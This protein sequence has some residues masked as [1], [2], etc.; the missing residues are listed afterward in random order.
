MKKQANAKPAF[1]HRLLPPRVALGV[2][3]LAALAV[4]VCVTIIQWQR[5]QLTFLEAE[6][7]ALQQVFLN[8]LVLTLNSHQQRTSH[9]P[10]A[11][12]ALSE[13]TALL[14]LE[15]DAG[16]AGPPNTLVD[17]EVRNNRTQVLAETVPSNPDGG[18]T[19]ALPSQGLEPGELTVAIVGQDD[20]IAYLIKLL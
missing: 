4:A 2:V 11:T 15:A 14:V 19:L 13:L 16:P 18:V 17:V 7:E 12:L 6:R 1:W 5:N 8:P 9:R 10:V 3:G 20:G